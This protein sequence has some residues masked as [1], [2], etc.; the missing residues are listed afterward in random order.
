MQVIKNRI[1]IGIKE[2]FCILHASD[3]HLAC[4]DG[5]ETQEKIALSLKRTKEIPMAEDNLNFIREKAQREKRTLAYTGDIIDFVSELNFEKA[6]DFCDSVDIIM[7]AGNHEFR[8]YPGEI[9]EDAD[10]RNISLGRVQ[11]IFK[12]DVRCS[13]RIINDVNFV[14]IDN[15]YYRIEK[16]Q[17]EFLKKETEKKYPV[18]LLVHIPLYTKEFYAFSR[19]YET[20]PAN[21][22]SVPEEFMQNYSPYRYEQQKQDEKTAEAYDFIVNCK[23]IRA[24]LAGHIHQNFEG[25]VSESIRQI[26]TDPSTVREIY[27]D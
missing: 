11:Q 6:K 19:Q 15:S 14:V 20:N 13:S 3:T 25:D 12:N 17:L 5:R 21:L 4:A 1:H 9:K 2:P 8:H 10:Y 24:I 22:L 18:I 27:I 23:N 26:T 16:E 7:S